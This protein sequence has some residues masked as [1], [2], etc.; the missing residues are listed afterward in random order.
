MSPSFRK[1]NPSFALMWLL[2]LINRWF[3]LKGLPVLRLIPLVRDL[4]LVRG[5]FRIRKVDFPLADRARLREAVNRGTAAFIG[6]NHPEFGFDWMMDKEVSTFVSPRMASWASH[7]IVATAPR[8]WLRNNLISHNGGEAAIDY[9]VRW[10]RRGYGVLLHPEGSVHW[11]ADKIHP[12]FHGIAEMACEAARRGVVEGEERPVYVVPIVWKLEYVGDVSARLHAEMH[13]IERSLGLDLDRHPHVGEHFRWL[14]ER[15]LK[16]RMLE[17]GFDPA[18]VNGLDF[19]L[20]QDVFRTWLMDDLGSRYPIEAHVS[21]E[22]RLT[23][24]KRAISA[25]RRA[26]RHDDTEDG[27]VRRAALTLDLSR[28]DEASRLDGLSREVYGTRQLNQVQM[29]ES[30]KRHRATLMTGGLRN[31]IHNFLPTPL[32]ARVAHVRVPDPIR[33]DSV[34]ASGTLDEREAYVASLIA[35]T[36]DRMQEALDSIN[37]ERAGEVA[38][39]SIPNPLFVSDH[40]ARNTAFSLV[41]SMNPVSGSA[42]RSSTPMASPSVSP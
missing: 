9:S 35:L 34:R 31:T 27:R 5:H 7:E 20:R 28:A 8:F 26:L 14:Q 21:V 32:G 42:A 18:S 22:R 40:S 25:E 23:R 30:L 41:K 12:L 24:F 37:R 39:Y 2:G 38:K 15:V 36:R 17:F 19:F 13:R 3:L 16:K 29:A 33:I 10:A 4:P 1:P 6:P 11:T